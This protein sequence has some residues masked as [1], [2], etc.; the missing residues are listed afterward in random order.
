[1]RRILAV[2]SSEAASSRP[3]QSV[4]FVAVHD[5][6][7]LRDCTFLNDSDGSQNCWNS[8]GD[9][10]LRGEREK[11]LIGRDSPQRTKSGNVARIP[12]TTTPRF[13]PGVVDG[14]FGKASRA[15]RL[16]ST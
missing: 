1:M 15:T 5:G 10:N 11:L 12:H 14:S 16:C 13:R 6:Y 3:W 4:N 2:V 7:T 8:D 9:E